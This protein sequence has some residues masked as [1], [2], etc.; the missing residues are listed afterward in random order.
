MS[1]ILVK[2]TRG[3]QIESIHRGHIVVANSKG[4]IIYQ[5]GDPDFKICLRSCAKPLQALPII[6]TGAADAFSLAPAELAT[7]SSCLNGQD[8]QVNTIKSVLN[9]MD[10][11]KVSCNV[12]F[13]TLHIA[14]QPRD[15]RK[16][17]GNPLPCTI[18]VRVN[19]LLYSLSAFI[20]DGRW[21][22]T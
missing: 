16:R 13:T 15:Y 9:K 8:F 20:T 3:N 17:E 4:E 10:L 18:I 12:E 1:E 5:L 14:Q 21:I 11:T 2:V 19:T 22:T 6:T 7:M